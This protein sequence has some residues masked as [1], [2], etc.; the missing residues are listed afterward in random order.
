MMQVK[1]HI[2]LSPYLLIPHAALLHNE[3]LIDDS[4]A[5][6]CDVAVK[7]RIGLTNL[8][9]ARQRMERNLNRFYLP[10]I[11]NYIT[12]KTLFASGSEGRGT[13]ERL[14]ATRAKLNELD[15]QIKSAWAQR[16]HRGQMRIAALMAVFTVLGLR[17]VLYELMKGT[18]MESYLWWD[19]F[20]LAG[21]VVLLYILWGMKH[22]D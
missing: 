11:F 14:I 19:L 13:N 18:A 8:E 2:G 20:G 17:D 22:S 3:A 7:H 16:H 1:N 4:E 15:G 21:V 12:E 10:N 9:N 5:A 6:L